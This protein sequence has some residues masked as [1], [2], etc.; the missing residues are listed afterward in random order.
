M[1]PKLAII[2]THPIQYYA[3]IFRL[4]TE[5]R[6]MQVK[7]FYTWEQAKEKV[8]DVNF[9]R[10]IKWDIPLLEGYDYTFVNNIAKEPGSHHFK[11]MD[12]PTLVGEV[13]IYKPDAILV[14]GWAFKSHLSLLRCFKGKVPIY[15]RGDSTVLNEQN[16]FKKILRKQ[17]LKWIYHHVDKAFYVGKRNRDYYLEFGLRNEQLIFAPHAIDNTRFSAQPESNTIVDFRSQLNIPE[18]AIIVLFAGK[19]EPRKSPKL[20]VN[21]F[22][23]VITKKL[24]LVMV[25]NGELETDIKSLSSSFDNI[26]FVD[27][28]NQKI[29]PSVYKLADVFVLTSKSET[30]GLA[31]N[32]AMACS[33]PVLVSDKCGCAIDLVEDGING[34]TFKS[35]DEEDLRAKLEL[36][37]RKSK[38]QLAVMG[39]NSFDKIKDW[40]F[41]KICNS[42]EA[43]LLD[44]A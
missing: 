39:E 3:P 20:L 34:Y 16:F 21:A 33:K 38:E 8:Y 18:D 23:K 41:E 29:M 10:E 1:L 42:I 31:V 32:E 43:T 9:K 13:K 17:F 14:F 15:F 4:L 25:G 11:G 7:V 35:G 28:Q 24:H 2:T 22:K 12:N 36:F 37:S 30:W 26:H 5:R 27:F 19:L 44:N 40:S 6:N